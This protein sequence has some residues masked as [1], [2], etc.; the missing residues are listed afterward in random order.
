MIFSEKEE[1]PNKNNLRVI[2]VEPAKAPKTEIMKNTL[3]AMQEIVGGSIEPVWFDEDTVLVANE[4]GKLKNLQLNR[5]IGTDIIAGTFFIVGDD[6]SEQFVSLTDEQIA[7]YMEVFASTNIDL[8][9]LS[10]DAFIDN[11]MILK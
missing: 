9:D 10:T 7:K 2:V 6:G 11:E 3:E 5:S 4:E 1:Q 8:Q